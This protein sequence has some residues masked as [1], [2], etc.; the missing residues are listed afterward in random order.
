MKPKIDFAFKKIMENEKARTGFYTF[1][2]RTGILFPFPH[3]GRH[4]SFRL[5]RQD[6]ISCHR[7]SQSYGMSAE[8]LR[9]SE[10]MG[11]IYQ[12]WKKEEFD[13]IA[14]KDPYIQS[15]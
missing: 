11:K 5:F 3:T 9:Q 12:C 15:A 4:P 14:G 13:M 10:I 2:K 6:G 1:W 7:A 8:R